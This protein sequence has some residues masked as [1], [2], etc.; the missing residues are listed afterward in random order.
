VTET[1]AAAGWYPD[2]AG[3]G[4]QRYFDGTAWTAHFV[5]PPPPM[6]YP[7]GK[8]PWKGAQY[9]RPAHGPGALA[10][11]GT[12]LGARLLDALVLLP[13]F[14]A[15]T[16]TT[17]ALVAPH[18]G[19]LFPRGTDDPN[20]TIPFPGIFWIYLAVFGCFLATGVVMV[21]Y[22]AIGTAR[23]GRT[24][25]KA[26]LH[27]RPVQ[28]NGQPLGFGRALGRVGPYF[29]TGFLSWIGLLDPLW[30]LWDENQQCLHDKIAGT[31]VVNDGPADEAPD[32]VATAGVTAAP[33]SSGS[34]APGQLPGQ[35]LGQPPPPAVAGNPYGPSPYGPS[36]YGVSPYGASPAAANPYAANPYGNNYWASGPALPRSN[37]L[38]IASLVCS[39]GG[40]LLLGLPSVVGLVLGLVARSQIRQSNGMQTGAGMALAGII[41]GMCVVVF[42]ILLIG[43]NVAVHH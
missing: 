15:F 12:R 6:A 2:P 31:L 35:P 18:V 13:V 1:S 30:C 43:V 39:I 37:G 34:W 4:G 29:L 40:L 3:T 17:I 33:S 19:P 14:A 23:Y 8:P 9:G 38:A 32:L 10:N 16:A 36:P 41:V 25:G 20:T 26:W 22:E 11:P 21:F 28:T 5:P 7:M 24:L 42:Y 27:I